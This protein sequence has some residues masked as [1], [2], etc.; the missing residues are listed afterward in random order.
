MNEED[1][2]KMLNDVKLPMPIGEEFVGEVVVMPTDV[3]YEALSTKNLQYEPLDPP[4]P[5]TLP[6]IDLV[7]P[8]LK[9][10]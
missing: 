9:R 6:K 3:F 2:Q 10:K 8:T 4:K 7:M 1:F 5:F